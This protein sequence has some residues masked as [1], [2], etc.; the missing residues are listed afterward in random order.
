M[1]NEQVAKFDVTNYFAQFPLF[2]GEDRAALLQ[3]LDNCARA[4]SYLTVPTD[5]LAKALALNRETRMLCSASNGSRQIADDDR[6]WE[7]ASVLADRKS[8]V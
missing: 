1:E 6:L 5:V 7:L 3:T 8:V 2:F 4:E